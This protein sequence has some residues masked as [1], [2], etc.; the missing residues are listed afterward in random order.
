LDI[1]ARPEIVKKRAPLVCHRL[2]PVIGC[3]ERLMPC[4]YAEAQVNDARGG[5]GGRRRS[6]QEGEA[7]E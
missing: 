4:G 7:K 5:R 2:V 6:T 1:G 3:A